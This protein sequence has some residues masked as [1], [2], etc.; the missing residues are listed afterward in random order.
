MFNWDSFLMEVLH[1]VS[2][3]FFFDKCTHI[4]KCRSIKNLRDIWNSIRVLGCFF[5]LRDIHLHQT[6]CWSNLPCCVF[7]KDPL[8]LQLHKQ[9]PACKT[10][11]IAIR[12]IN[13]Q[14]EWKPGIPIP[15]SQCKQW[16]VLILW[17]NSNEKFCR[18]RVIVLCVYVSISP[19]RYSRM[20][21]NLPPVWKA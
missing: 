8:S 1:Y 15:F 17:Q 7:H 9:F 12:S 4:Y 18:I 21:Y 16:P 10:H 11:K 14:L 6:D 19:L 2:L 3:V 5:V 13:S 20:R